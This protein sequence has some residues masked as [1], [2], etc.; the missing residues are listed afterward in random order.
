V[1]TISIRDA[2]KEFQ[3]SRPTLT[4]ALN[5]GKVSG[6]KDDN[7][8]WM[9]ETSEISRVYKPRAPLPDK[10]HVKLSDKN[11][12]EHHYMKGKLEALESYVDDLKEQR[13]KAENRADA[14]EARVTAL[15]SDQSTKRRGWWL[16]GK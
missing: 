5:N 6:K 16:W 3:V 4:K 13:N 15:L 11:T 7:G 10:E 1:A 14:A 2:V 8:T 12:D 9:M